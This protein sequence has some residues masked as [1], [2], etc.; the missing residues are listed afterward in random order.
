MREWRKREWRGV[1][2]G[3]RIRTEADASRSSYPYNF[4]DRSRQART[5]QLGTISLLLF[6]SGPATDRAFS[7]ELPFGR[8]H[9]GDRGG[10]GRA[11]HARFKYRDEDVSWLFLYW[12]ERKLQR[13][14]HE[15][16]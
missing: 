14:S 1:G 4:N 12:S 9:A 2:R 7:F 11:S 8:V 15:K 13:A 16:S 5:F 6:P 3:L 10:G